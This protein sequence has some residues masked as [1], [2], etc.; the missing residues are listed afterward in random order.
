MAEES[1]LNKTDRL[2]GKPV[3]D[4]FDE[5]IANLRELGDFYLKEFKPHRFSGSATEDEENKMDDKL[6][7]IAAKLR[8][9]G[10]KLTQLK[11]GSRK[12]RGLTKKLRRKRRF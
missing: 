1:V 6:D 3:P 10:A 2:L 8:D 9:I 12:R 11:G 4:T 7:L 5:C